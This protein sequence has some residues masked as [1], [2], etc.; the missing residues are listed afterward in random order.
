V[1]TRV[2]ALLTSLLVALGLLVV[3]EGASSGAR[4]PARITVAAT[5]RVA[6][7]APVKQLSAGGQHGCA[8]TTSS[9]LTCW[10]D[11]T[12]GQLT[13]PKGATA[14]TPV[15]VGNARNWVQVSAGGSH[16]CA[17]TANHRLQCWGLNHFGGLG[18]GRTKTTNKRVKVFKAKRYASVAAGWYQTCAIRMNHR[19]TCW[20]ENR[21]GELGTGNHKRAVKPQQVKGKQGWSQVAVGGWNTCGVKLDGSLWC[22]GGNQWGQLGIGSY[23]DAAKPVRVGTRTDWSQVSATWS[24]TCAI[25]RGGQVWCWGNNNESQLGNG[26][27]TASTVPVQVATTAV[28]AQVAVGEGTSCLLDSTGRV[29]CWGYN[30]YGQI[31]DAS[32]LVHTT[33]VVRSTGVSAISAGWLYTCDLKTGGAVT[34]YGDNETGQLGN[35]T[36]TDTAY[37]LAPGAVIGARTLG[38]D[39][40]TPASDPSA[41]TTPVADPTPT[42]SPTPDPTSYTLAPGAATDFRLST[43]NLLGNQHT[44][45]GTDE[46]YRAPSRIRAEWTAQALDLLGLD[47][48][49]TQEAQAQQLGWILKATHGEFTSYATPE[50]GNRWT[51]AALLWR[52]SAFTAIRTQHFNAPYLQVAMP[53]PLVLLQSRATGRQMWVMDVHNAPWK[54][55]AQQKKRDAAMKIEVAKVQRYT[56]NGVAFFFVGDFN[57]KAKAFC[58]V[59]ANTSLRSPQHGRIMRGGVCKPPVNQRIDWLFGSNGVTWSNYAQTRTPLVAN[60]TDHWVQVASVHLP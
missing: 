5:H 27:Q 60:A 14:S 1:N 41:S 42:V 58:T 32:T 20:G 25:T 17:V 24:H 57:E 29:L 55:K 3:V 39:E 45:P 7:S 30:G 4:P 8:I 54:S 13:G 59:L 38:R 40:T 47:V 36:L 56:K 28:T 31:G 53:R 23:S 34:C 18:N 21:N 6:T 44:L 35:G 37:P 11:N 46:D 2:A 9:A 52:T 12:Y 15:A 33:P 49:G 51:E 10:G 50:Q 19:M 26:T 43:F 16:T 22:W 48:V